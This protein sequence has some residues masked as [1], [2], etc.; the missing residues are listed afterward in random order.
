M[1]QRNYRYQVAFAVALINEVSCVCCAGLYHRI[2][3]PFRLIRD[4][5]FHEPLQLF[6]VNIVTTYAAARAKLI[7]QG[8]H[9]CLEAICGFCC[10]AR[11]NDAITTVLCDDID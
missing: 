9:E 4:V 11:H 5:I 7:T 2:F 10:A 3:L 1:E 6:L 8:L